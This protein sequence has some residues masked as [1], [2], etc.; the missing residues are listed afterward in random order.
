MTTNVDDLEKI[1]DKKLAANQAMSNERLTE[2]E[3]HFDEKLK[4][5]ESAVT[6]L[7][8][9]NPQAGIPENGF[10]LGPSE[11]YDKAGKNGGS[12]TFSFFVKEKENE[13][14]AVSALHC[15]LVNKPENDEFSLNLPPLIADLAEGVCVYHTNNDNEDQ[16]LEDW[17]AFRLSREKTKEV[18]DGRNMRAYQWP[19]IFSSKDLK[20]FI[21]VKPNTT[22]GYSY[23]A[24]V[25]GEHCV[26]D[27]IPERMVSFIINKGK[28]EDS[29]AI[30]FLL[31]P[32]IIHDP[33]LLGVFNGHGP[34]LANEHPNRA[35][36]TLFPC[37]GDSVCSFEGKTVSGTKGVLWKLKVDDTAIKSRFLV[38]LKRFK[39]SKARKKVD[40]DDSYKGW[41]EV[42]QGALEEDSEEASRKDVKTNAN[43]D[44]AVGQDSVQANKEGETDSVQSLVEAA[45][46]CLC[47][48]IS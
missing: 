27:N 38:S 33:M 35:F 42:V 11:S 43:H 3:H 14:Y 13:Y 21:Q 8:V 44:N 18:L 12:A 16:G 6:R 46:E 37:G 36:I 24:V 2:L 30:M 20:G 23:C 41:D 28:T 45:E 47:C 9:A 15:V 32:A 39:A 48:T 1:L 31:N 29:G 25:S 5:L 7:L 10:V 4:P 19:E 17:V 22:A 34:N 40:T 26:Y